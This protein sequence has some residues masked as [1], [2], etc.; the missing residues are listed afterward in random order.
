MTMFCV[1][2]EVLSTPV[3]PAVKATLLEL[4][5]EWGSDNWNS[6]PNQGWNATSDPCADGW[7]GITCDGN[8][9]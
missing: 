5:A 8:N 6:A 4:A 3:A 7:Y 9:V 1:L 2:H